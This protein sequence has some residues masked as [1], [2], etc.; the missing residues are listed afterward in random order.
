MKNLFI[1]IITVVALSGCSVQNTFTKKNSIKA[2]SS[3][4][5]YFS[6]Y[7][8]H[9]RLDDKISLSIWDHDD[10][11]VGSLF[12]IYNSNEVYGKWVQVNA[13]GMIVIPKLGSVHVLGLS[14]QE[15]EQMLATKYATLIV[16][17]VLKLKVLNREMSVLGEVK[18]PGIFLLEKDQINLL[19][20]IA[21]A[22]DFE[23]YADK[24]FIRLIRNNGIKSK[25]Y[26]LDFT[27]MTDLEK[28]SVRVLPGDVLYVPTRKG[29][30]LDKKAPTLIPFASALT[31]AAIFLSL[32]TK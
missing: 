18:N 32:F 30:M 27:E 6:S 25:Q 10:L 29:K 1:I 14:I 3:L 31:T 28:A 26:E 22:G 19:D 2:D 11:S 7:E 20:I 13:A 15:A 21:R 8:Y 12:G 5:N 23:F 16:N 9:I 4:F 24:R 17:P